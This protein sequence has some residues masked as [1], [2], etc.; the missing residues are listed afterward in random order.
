MIDQDH[1]RI[2]TAN[3]YQSYMRGWKNGACV[4]AMDS[5]FIGREKTNPMRKYYEIGY[6]DGRKA[7]NNAAN[8]ATNVTGHVP[9]VLRLADGERQQR[10]LFFDSNRTQAWRMLPYVASQPDTL[11]GGRILIIADVHAGPVE[12]VRAAAAFNDPD[13][14][15]DYRPNQSTLTW[16]NGVVARVVSPQRL[17]T[18]RGMDV[19]LALVDG[20]PSEVDWWNIVEPMV[21]RGR[22][23]I[24]A[25]DDPPSS[26]SCVPGSEATP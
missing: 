16:R 23:Q 20:W 25:V 14:M 17:E 13:A 21:R 5:A 6:S 26:W 8:I 3:H 9:A 18:I 2:D 10:Y 15:P 19:A 4:N 24:V 12:A 1:A 7:R 22:A 11:D